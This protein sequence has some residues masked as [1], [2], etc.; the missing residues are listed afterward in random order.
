MFLHSDKKERLAG[1]ATAKQT[2]GQEAT[3]RNATQAGLQHLPRYGKDEDGG[4]KKNVQI[5]EAEIQRTATYL[6]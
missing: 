6:H 4:K 1:S 3:Q 5:K 2:R